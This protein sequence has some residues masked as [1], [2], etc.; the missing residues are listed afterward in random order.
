MNQGLIESASKMAI[1]VCICWLL[2]DRSIKTTYRKKST[3]TTQ[4]F[5]TI[6]GKY[7]KRIY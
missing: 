2:N 6:V 3:T 7:N 4:R 1:N 5:I